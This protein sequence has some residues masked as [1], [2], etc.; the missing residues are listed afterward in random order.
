MEAER[1]PGPRFGSDAA[2]PGVNCERWGGVLSIPVT[3]RYRLILDGPSSDSLAATIDG[4]QIDGQPRELVAG[5]AAFTVTRASSSVPW[6]LRLTPVTGGQDVPILLFTSRGLARGLVGTYYDN[7]R[8]EGDPVV[9]RH[10]WSLLPR[11]VGEG[12]FG[13]IWRGFMTISQPGR[14][15]FFL[16][17]D[18]AAQL[19]I[20]G[21]VLLEANIAT[22]Q[23]AVERLISLEAGKHP[24]EIRFRNADGGQSFELQWT[25][26]GREGRH[27]IPLEALSPY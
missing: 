12:P 10:D 27:L 15:I 17:A 13:I 23:R 22:G 18:D 19:S 2:P 6:T 26:P 5:F 24:V 7:A 16:A 4:Q 9:V 1:D 11:P 8:F 14:Y 21:N 3:G 20:D 25:P